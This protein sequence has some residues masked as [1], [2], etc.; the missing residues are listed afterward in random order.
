MAAAVVLL[1]PPGNGPCGRGKRAAAICCFHRDRAS[2]LLKSRPCLEGS[3]SVLVCSA[4]G[5]RSKL[6]P[7][8]RGRV[9]ASAC[10]R[11]R[12]CASARTHTRV[13]RARL[14]VSRA[15]YVTVSVSVV[16]FANGLGSQCAARL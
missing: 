11:A 1:S 4:C 2:A 16:V 10:V 9:R 8:V 12:G 7:R 6:R 13:V 14:C 15:P 5:V 3:S